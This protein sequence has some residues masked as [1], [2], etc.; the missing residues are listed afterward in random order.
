MPTPPSPGDDADP[1]A[2]PDPMIGSADGNA[3]DALAS[4]TDGASPVPQTDAGTDLGTTAGPKMP[5]QHSH[6]LSLAQ[7]GAR[8]TVRLNGVWYGEFYG[9]TLRDITMRL[10]PGP[11][12]LTVTYAPQNASSWLA[13]H[14]TEGEHSPPIPDLVV[15]RIEPLRQTGKDDMTGQPAPTTRTFRFI[16]Q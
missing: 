5:T 16:A 12:T 4:D 14:V 6:W 7:F 9:P 15:Y 8:V 11:N 2:P 13:V 3:A 1:L 10:Q